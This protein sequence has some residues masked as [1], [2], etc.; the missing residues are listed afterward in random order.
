[1][2]PRIEEANALY[3]FAPTKSKVVVGSTS[4]GITS[5]TATNGEGVNLGSWKGALSNDN[6]H[7][8]VTAGTSGLDANMTF[9]RVKLNG[10]NTLIFVTEI[11][12][13][14]TAPA[15]LMQICDWV[16]AN[17]VDNA[18]DSECTGGGWRTLNL[19]KAT[20]VPTTATTYVYYAYDGYWAS[21]TLNSAVDTP[22]DNFVNASNEIK[23]RFYST[24]NTATSLAVDYFA[25]FAVVNPVYQPADFV[26]NTAGTVTG[27]Y[28]NINGVTAGA[29]DNTYF[30]V[31]GTA[32]L[33]ADF[34]F[35]MKNVETYPGANAILVRAEY[36]CDTTGITHR[37]KIYNFTSGSWE[38]LTT[39]NIAC[40]ATDATNAW[41][42][43]NI[44]VDDYISSS[45][46]E[47]WIGWR[48]LAANATNQIKLDQLYAMIG[49]VNSDVSACEISMGTNSANTCANSRDLDMTGTTNTWSILA[50]DE[51]TSMSHD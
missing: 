7:W 24:T 10:A 47:M 5:A 9:G 32:A 29:S 17:S 44:D 46:N 41:S 8:M 2:L 15:L 36:A 27:N 16:S 1:M 13:D 50:E 12:E 33:P 21:T 42:K 43:S 4:T 49:T 26:N 45:T 35:K 11:D 25:I 3:Q 22:L 39:A 38:D 18:A 31:A 28:M 30:E 20:V 19:R 34:Y 40:S 48:A 14:A 23:V 37:P 6:F 51:S